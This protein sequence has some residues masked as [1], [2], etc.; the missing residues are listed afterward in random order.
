MPNAMAYAYAIAAMANDANGNDNVINL[1]TYK[2]LIT[3][4]NNILHT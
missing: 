1:L 3:N 4:Y 2:Y